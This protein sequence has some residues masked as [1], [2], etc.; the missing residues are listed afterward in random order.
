[1]PHLSLR[2]ASQ[3]FAV[4]RQTLGKALE[5]GVISGTKDD[6]G[7]WQIDSAELLRVYKPRPQ[8]GRTEPPM[9]STAAMPKH[10][11]L[12][13]A[14]AVDD[15]AVTIAR[16]TAELAAEKEMRALEREML[17][18]HLDDVRRLLPAPEAPRRRSWWP[19]R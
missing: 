8:S 16:L 1:M 13:A 7:N 14:A 5:N 2:Q 6:T 11:P 4:S 12:Q 10:G 18:R 3:Q 17:Q 19:W 9:Q 15:S